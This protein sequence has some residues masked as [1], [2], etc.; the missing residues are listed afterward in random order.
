MSG[1]GK[2]W[3]DEEK[4]AYREGLRFVFDFWKGMAGWEAAVLRG[5]PRDGGPKAGY[6]L[7]IHEIYAAGGSVD[8]AIEYV[9]REVIGSHEVWDRLSPDEVSR[10]A[11]HDADR[12]ADIHVRIRDLHM[13]GGSTDEVVALI[14]KEIG[15]EE[16]PA[17]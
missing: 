6:E 9:R 11:V 13:G 17:P 14:R 1:T 2:P 3:T 4:D 7:R 15:T 10:L 8:D 12:Q 16:T 5:M